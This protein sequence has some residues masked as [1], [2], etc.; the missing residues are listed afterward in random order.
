[1]NESFGCRLLVPP[2]LPACLPDCL[3]INSCTLTDE[4]QKRREKNSVGEV[5][6]G[7]KRRKRGRKDSRRTRRCHQTDTSVYAHMRPRTHM[8]TRTQSDKKR[9]Q[10][11]K[12]ERRKGLIPQQNGEMSCR[13]SFSS[14]LPPSPHVLPCCG[15][16][17][18]SPSCLPC[19]L[20]SI[21]SFLFEMQSCRCG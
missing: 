8:H 2:C 10:K 3:H 16:A 14:C 19:L 15:F 21:P 12:K 20:Y 1:L 17:L 9:E 11:R 13:L 4:Q 6:R 7:A 18:L 5:L